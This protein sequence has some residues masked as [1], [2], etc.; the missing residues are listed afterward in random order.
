MFLVLVVGNAGGGV[1]FFFAVPGLLD[2]MHFA[3]I[4]VVA[5]GS[6]AGSTISLH[7]SRT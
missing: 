1:F 5:P 7:R 3:V 4:V 6:S 2:K